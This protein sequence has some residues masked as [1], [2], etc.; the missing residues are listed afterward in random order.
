M[1]MMLGTTSKAEK[2]KSVK[3]CMENEDNTGRP[4]LI[5]LCVVIWVVVEYF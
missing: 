4:A 3:V 5:V 2:V 1:R